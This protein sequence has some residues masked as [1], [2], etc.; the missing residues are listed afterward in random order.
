MAIAFVQAPAAAS[1]YAS[2]TLAYNSNIASGNLLTC[3][4]A[5][6]NGSSITAVTTT[7]TR[8]TSYNGLVGVATGGVPNRPWLNYG[9]SRSAGACTITIGIP[10]NSSDDI[11]DNFGPGGEGIG[12]DTTICVAATTGVADADTGAPA[13]NDLIIN[14]F[15]K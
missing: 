4:G 8:S 1:N 13:A 6:W 9:M 15:Y 5:C 12:F 2:I 7:D 3:T 11:S 10:G 14:V